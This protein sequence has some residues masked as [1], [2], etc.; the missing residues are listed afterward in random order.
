MPCPF[1]EIVKATAPAVAVEAS[2]PVGAAMRCPFHEIVKAT[3]PAVAPRAREIVD[4][5]YPRMFANNPETKA[6]FNPANQFEEPNRQRMA[7]TNA[8]LAYAGNIENLGA[9]AEA[10]A[11]ITHKHAGLVV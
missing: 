3:V 11:I 1:H 4:D 6:L 2:H 5:F 7:L 9:L 10:V 8:V